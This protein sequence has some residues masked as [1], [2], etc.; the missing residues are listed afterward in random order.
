[1]TTWVGE[2][3]VSEVLRDL[4]SSSHRYYW[5]LTLTEDV[6]VQIDIQKYLAKVKVCHYFHLEYK[7]L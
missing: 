5:A 4:I 6:T 2:Y 7:N 1:M 3:A